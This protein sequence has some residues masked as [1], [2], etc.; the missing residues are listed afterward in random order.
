M[1]ISNV[2]ASSVNKP[3]Y[4]DE[5]ARKSSEASPVDVQDSAE[6][7]DSGRKMSILNQEIESI[8][9][10]IDSL[11]DIREGKIQSVEEKIAAGY[12]AQNK[13]LEELAA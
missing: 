2:G 6:I 13:F 8:R 12:Y 5:S 9:K 7:S 4:F 3:S 1:D 11:P 10:R